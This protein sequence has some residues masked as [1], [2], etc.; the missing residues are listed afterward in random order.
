MPATTSGAASRERHPERNIY[1][2]ETRVVVMEQHA[3]TQSFVVASG[4][5][6]LGIIVGA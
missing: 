2:G 1:D 4:I 3:G 6:F 5:A